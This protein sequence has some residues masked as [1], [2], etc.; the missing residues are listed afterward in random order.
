MDVEDYSRIFE[1]AFLQEANLYPQAKKIKL[2]YEDIKTSTLLYRG[3]LHEE[4]RTVESIADYKIIHEPFTEP[5]I[6]PAVENLATNAA[7]LVDGLIR[8]EN[9]RK[10]DGTDPRTIQNLVVTD[11]FEHSDGR[12]NFQLNVVQSPPNV[13]DPAAFIPGWV[14]Y[15]F[16]FACAAIRQEYKASA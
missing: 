3:S 2:P 6:I 9:T 5:W 11:V 1:E 16:Y 12:R 15:R 10:R 14:S 8:I 4:S 13:A 7:A